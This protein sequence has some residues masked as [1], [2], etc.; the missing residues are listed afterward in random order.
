M[1]KRKLIFLMLSLICASALTACNNEHI[2]GPQGPQG[3]TGERGE[4]GVSIV[5]VDLTSSDGLVD[6]YTI[7]YSDGT[8]SN[9][10]VTNGKNGEQGIQGEPG[11]DGHTPIITIG[12]NGN[13]YIDGDDTGVL[14]EGVQGPQGE[15]GE[16]GLDGEDGLSAYEIYIKYHPEYT[17]TEEEWLEDLV[18]GD[19]REE[20]KV[21][22]LNYDGSILEVDENVTYNSF[23]SY[24]GAV[25]TRESD[26][27]YDYIFDEWSPSLKSVIGDQIYVATYEIKVKKN[28]SNFEFDIKINDEGNKYISITNSLSITK[29]IIIPEIIN[30]DGE[31][32]VVEEIGKYAFAGN[33]YIESV[34]IPDTV[35]L[36]DDFAFENCFRLNKVII[37]SKSSQLEE[38]GYFAFSYCDLLNMIVIPSSIKNIEGY[39]FCKSFDNISTVFL[40]EEF[41]ETPGEG[42]KIYNVYIY[43]GHK[44]VCGEENFYKYILCKD[45]NNDKYICIY[46]YTGELSSI[47]IPSYIYIDGFNYPVKSFIP[48][49]FNISGLASITF[50]NTFESIPDSAF[51]IGAIGSSGIGGNL[52][53]VNLP[54]TIK[55]IGSRAFSENYLLTSIIIPS[56]VTIIGSEAFYGCDSL[57]IYCEVAS[58]PSGWSDDWNPSQCSVVWDYLNKN[59]TGEGFSVVSIKSLNKLN[60]SSL[61]NILEYLKK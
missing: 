51:W 60:K 27:K 18:N 3:E 41:S 20:Y 16:D 55:V 42:G 61:K 5:S 38:I 25:P 30:V 40:Y 29:S 44:F 1:K 52:R 6:I 17:G 46:D 32:I 15:P 35:K 37:N 4:D 28:N 2:I 54:N 53:E 10:I 14:A 34:S 9:F 24:N 7:T 50:P 58:K 45:E 11:E 19:L 56:S 49:I 36:I 22:W 12:E 13:W 39:A 43:D 59:I 31:D 21:T 26:D 47:V 57:T 33:P 48:G 8:T 23:P